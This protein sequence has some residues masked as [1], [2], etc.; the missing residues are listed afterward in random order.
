MVP[1]PEQL[2][3]QEPSFTLWTDKEKR[4]LEIGTII[5]F[6]GSVVEYGV[7]YLEKPETK[8]NHHAQTLI[9]I[10]PHEPMEAGTPPFNIAACDIVSIGLTM[11]VR[12]AAHLHR[13]RRHASNKRNDAIIQQLENSLSQPDV[14]GI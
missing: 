9:S 10:S 6:V 12:Y 2:Q 11:A 4:A 8:D 7:L 13:R 3:S 5:G 14:Q 1:Q